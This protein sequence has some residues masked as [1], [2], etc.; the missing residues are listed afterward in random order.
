MNLLR[1]R[2]LRPTVWLAAV[3]VLV[4]AP[5]A[6]MAAEQKASFRVGVEVVEPCSLRAAHGR[7]EIGCA[8]DATR[9]ARPSA[10]VGQIQGAQV[11]ELWCGPVA[12][13]SLAG[14][15]GQCAAAPSAAHSLKIVAITF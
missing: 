8:A 7:I 5:A 6:G 4:L 1:N 3:A 10:S 2:T 15:A 12:T 13:P 9:P 11:E 14:T